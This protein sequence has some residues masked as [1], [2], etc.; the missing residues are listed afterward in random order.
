VSPDNDVQSAVEKAVAAVR[1]EHG[2]AVSAL[3]EELNAVQEYHTE[4]RKQ[5][6]D[7]CDQCDQFVKYR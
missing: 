2:S 5:L 6:K 3:E 7:C 4:L 1:E